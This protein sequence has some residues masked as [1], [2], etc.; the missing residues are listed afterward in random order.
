MLVANIGITVV[1]DI[2][3]RNRGSILTLQYCFS[4]CGCV[5][6][7]GFIIHM[8]N[9]SILTPNAHMISQN[10]PISHT[11]TVR[12]SC[13][14]RES[15]GLQCKGKENEWESAAMVTGPAVSNSNGLLGSRC[16]FV[17]LSRIEHN[18]CAHGKWHRGGCRGID[19]WPQSHS[20]TNCRIISF[21]LIGMFDCNV[22]EHCVRERKVSQ[23]YKEGGL[24][25]TEALVCADG[26]VQPT[27]AKYCLCTKC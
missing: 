9:V 7:Q 4:L 10:I 20:L 17:R 19:I 21:H 12:F 23:T 27:H 16:S 26:E 1:S 2:L 24:L 8:L 15:K 5:E 22:F 14:R 18:A 13:H 6:H 3:E 11:R 25:R